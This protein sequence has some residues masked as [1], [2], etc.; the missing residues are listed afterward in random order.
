M[1]SHRPL[2][3]VLVLLLILGCCSTK[4]IPNPSAFVLLL[5]WVCRYLPAPLLRLMR[6]LPMRRYI[7]FRRSLDT[8][9]EYS[10]KLIEEKSAALFH[11]TEDN[12]RDVMNILG[13][14]RLPLFSAVARNLINLCSLQ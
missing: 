5:G 10:R 13:R 11:G 6:H 2:S 1:C 12:K 14:L 4:S 8:L 7:H 3:A 9:N